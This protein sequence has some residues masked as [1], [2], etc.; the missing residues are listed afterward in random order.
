MTT[1]FLSL[2]I[3]LILKAFSVRILVRCWPNS[4]L[5]EA[6]VEASEPL[7]STHDRSESAKPTFKQD[8]LSDKQLPWEELAV[9]NVD[10][11]KTRL[12]KCW[13]NPLAPDSSGSLFSCRVC[14]ALVLAWRLVIGVELLRY[15]SP[16][17]V[18]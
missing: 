1:T 16:A 4:L 7:L 10:D 13:L 9:Q 5:E 18:F 15:V 8:G 2:I 14:F 6:A 17:G 12:R 3:S 11:Q